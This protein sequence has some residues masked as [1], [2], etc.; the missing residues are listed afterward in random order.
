MCG[1]AGKLEI[2]GSAQ[3]EPDTVNRMT[4]AL[5]HRGP[6]DQG[7]WVDGHVGLGSRRLAIID[8]SA[9]A[10]QPMTNEDGSLRIAFNGEIYNFQD[11]RAYL[12]RK[13]HRFQSDG[14]TEAILHLYE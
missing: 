7:I 10:R 13:G 8:L 5:R 9:R 12:E 3:V 14:D 4:L 11:L 1:I 6:D 2:R